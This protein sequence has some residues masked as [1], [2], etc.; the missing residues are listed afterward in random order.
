MNSIMLFY[1]IACHALMDYAL[2]GD[3]MAVCKCRRA[4]HPLQKSVP[5]FYWLSAHAM[6]H[7]MAVGVVIRW[8][9]YDMVTATTFAIIETVIHWFVDLGKCE[10]FFNIHVDQGIHIACKIAWWAMLVNGNFA[11]NG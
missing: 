5:W 6:L 2:Q 10:Q 3:A 9:G 1:L 7:G 8:F 4:N 11:I